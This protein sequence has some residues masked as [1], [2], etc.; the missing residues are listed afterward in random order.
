MDEENQPLSPGPSRP[1][2]PPREGEVVIDVEQLEKELQR[3]DPDC[4]FP[5]GCMCAGKVLCFPLWC[6]H[7]VCPLRYFTSWSLLALCIYLPLYHGLKWAGQEQIAG[8]TLWE[9]VIFIAP[10]STA[11]TFIAPEFRQLISARLHWSAF[12]LLHFIIHLLPLILVCTL[13]ELPHPPPL[14]STGLFLGL[15]VVYMVILAAY[16]KI[17]PLKNYLVLRPEQRGTAIKI[18]LSFLVSSVLL[19]E[20]LFAYV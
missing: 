4:P 3:P 15:L 19:C 18:T 8:G 13:I 6:F 1:H 7:K 9:M 12:V 16:W 14:A 17:D 2:D 5:G 11:Q 10:V 20:L